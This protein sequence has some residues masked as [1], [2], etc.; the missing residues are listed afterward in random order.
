MKTPPKNQLHRGLSVLFKNSWIYRRKLLVSLWVQ[1]NGG[2][3]I[4]CGAS[5]WPAR[6]LLANVANDEK[7]EAN[8]QLS[9]LC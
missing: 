9:V 1:N 5:G 6:L 8:G 4:Y 2:I 7:E 3:R